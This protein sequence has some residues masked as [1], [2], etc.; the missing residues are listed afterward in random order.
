MSMIN[1]VGGHKP[2]TTFEPIETGVTAKSSRISLEGMEALRKSLAQ[3]GAEKAQLTAATNAP[4]Q[5]Q[6]ALN[7]FIENDERLSQGMAAMGTLATNAKFASQ[8]L[9]SANKD[10]VDVTMAVVGGIMGTGLGVLQAIVSEQPS[11]HVR[12]AGPYAKAENAVDAGIESARQLVAELDPKSANMAGQ[13]LTGIE[14]IVGNSL[15][16]ASAASQ[17]GSISSILQ[18]IAG[19]LKGIGG[20]V[21]AATGKEV[22]GRV[23]SVLDTVGKG[24]EVAAEGIQPGADPFE[25]AGKA[26]STAFEQAGKIASTVKGE[27]SAKVAAALPPAGDIVQNILSMASNG[28][29]GKTDPGTMAQ[30]MLGVLGGTT[31]LVS[32]I[33]TGQ[34]A[35]I[36][37]RSLQPVATTFVMA[38]DS[39]LITMGKIGSDMLKLQE[40][41]RLAEAEKDKMQGEQAK[42]TQQQA[43]KR[44]NINAG[45]SVAAAAAGAGVA[46]GG[47]ATAV[48]ANKQT[49]V[50]LE[51]KQT[52]LTPLQNQK[53]MLTEH[54]QG[55]AK[56]T[57]LP[58]EKQLRLTELQAKQ[59]LSPEETTELAGLQREVDIRGMTHQQ[60]QADLQRNKAEI[61]RIESDSQVKIN[62]IQSAASVHAGNVATG[63]AQG[64]TQLT[65][66]VGNI[67]T[68]Q[69]EVKQMQAEEGKK[70]A[71]KLANND[72]AMQDDLKAVFQ[73]SQDIVNRHVD[74]R[75]GVMQKTV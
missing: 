58:P 41:L 49:N 25:T 32:A 1:D 35:D 60:A 75:I 19:A 63:S 12:T 15:A 45:F 33:T 74:S 61:Q 29:N 65:S 38:Q 11:T 26:A 70:Y 2:V 8:P 36:A 51:N 16:I 53:S 54:I 17:G 23:N 34:V 62:K 9:P 20:I 66:G 10:P 5:K 7:Y 57:Q 37:S 43:I 56:P 52:Q 69:E 28:V 42:L 40:D 59:N 18:S 30:H 71:E 39:T 24:L 13:V 48:N 72:R 3:T 68:T 22:A 64:V 31:N 47:A 46:V 67:F 6:E 4:Q 27:T 50:A 21:A 55:G 73:K 14:D 44:A